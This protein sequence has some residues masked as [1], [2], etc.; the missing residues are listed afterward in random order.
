MVMP[1]ATVAA[2]LS[3]QTGPLP[4][5]GR[6]LPG[7]FIDRATIVTNLALTVGDSHRIRM[8]PVLKGTGCPSPTPARSPDVST[9]LTMEMP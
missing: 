6:G 2:A 4:W 9:V 8:S 5:P 3:I 1:P 7:R